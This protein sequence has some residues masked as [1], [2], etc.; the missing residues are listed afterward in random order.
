MGAIVVDFKKKLEEKHQSVKVLRA[1]EGLRAF[2]SLISNYELLI[3]IYSPTLSPKVLAELTPLT[4]EEQLAE[5]LARLNDLADTMEDIVLEKQITLSEAFLFLKH[6]QEE[7]LS[8]II[9]Y[10]LEST[11]PFFGP[12]CKPS[13]GASSPSGF[14]FFLRGLEDTL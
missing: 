7:E 13:S 3:Q 8:Q 12:C 4:P 9:A 14:H 10:L 6:G 1:Q 11:F 5:D 2:R